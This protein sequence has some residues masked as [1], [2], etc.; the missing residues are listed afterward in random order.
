VISRNNG[1]SENSHFLSPKHVIIPRNFSPGLISVRLAGAQLLRP[2]DRFGTVL[3]LP[4]RN[5]FTSRPSSED[6]LLQVSMPSFLFLSH[7]NLEC[8]PVLSSMHQCIALLDAQLCV[9]DTDEIHLSKQQ[10]TT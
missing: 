6:T 7:R 10:Q 5:T 9:S 2:A 1:I 3:N 4:L 8:R